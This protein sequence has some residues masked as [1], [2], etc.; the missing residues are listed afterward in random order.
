MP[1]YCSNVLIVQQSPRSPRSASPHMLRTSWQSPQ[2]ILTRQLPEIAACPPHRYTRENAQN[3]PWNF[4][5]RNLI[6]MPQNPLASQPQNPLASQPQPQNVISE[7]SMF[8]KTK[9]KKSKNK[10]FNQTISF[11]SSLNPIDFN[12]FVPYPKSM[13]HQDNI[14]MHYNELQMLSSQID[15]TNYINTNKLSIRTVKEI[16]LFGLGNKDELIFYEDHWYRN[17][18]G[19]K[20]NSLYTKII[21]NTSNIIIYVFTT[22][23]SPPLPIILAMSKK[24]PSLTFSLLYGEQGND[25]AGV[26]VIN[27]TKTIHA[28]DYP[29]CIDWA[30]PHSFMAKFKLT[31]YTN[32]IEGQ[33]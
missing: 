19:T 16:I 25:F 28:N 3:A 15:K 5:R 32:I 11:T 4:L 27:N 8:A 6:N 31:Q 14:R 13:L 10:S 1:N 22:A 9:L 12:N 30:H 18:W 21:H 33:T 24:F 17:N 26:R 7:F 20:W 2:D 23:W 29:Y